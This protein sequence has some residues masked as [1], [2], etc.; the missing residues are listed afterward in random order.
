[1]LGLEVNLVDV[2]VTIKAEDIPD[3]GA[4]TYMFPVDEDSFNKGKYKSPKIKPADKSAP[5]ASL[6]IDAIKGKMKFSGKNLDLTGLSC[7]ITIT[8]QIG[9]PAAEIVLDED[10]VNGPKK[11]CPPELMMGI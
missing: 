7:P 10:I 1:M 8:I 9:D 6:Q 3:V 11:P 4:T 2:I 5:I